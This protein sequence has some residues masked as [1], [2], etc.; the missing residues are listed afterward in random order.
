MIESNEKLVASILQWDRKILEFLF[1]K[2]VIELGINLENQNKPKNADTEPKTK[3]KTKQTDNYHKMSSDYD[4]LTQR[5]TKWVKKVQT[6]KT[7]DKNTTYKKTKTGIDLN[8]NK[9]IKLKN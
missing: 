3:K 4:I 2:L 7:I 8:K 1:K 6:R 5:L 9:T